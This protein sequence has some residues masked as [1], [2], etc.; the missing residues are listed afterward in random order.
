M[1]SYN[2]H[3]LMKVGR[4]INTLLFLALFP[5]ALTTIEEV[6]KCE[7]SFSKLDKQEACLPK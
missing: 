2:P 1:F 3:N 5:F 6:P 4:I 7:C